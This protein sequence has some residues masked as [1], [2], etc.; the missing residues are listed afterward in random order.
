MRRPHIDL[1]RNQL[2]KQRLHSVHIPFGLFCS[3][4]MYSVVFFG[5]WAILLPFIDVWEKPSRHFAPANITEI[6]YSAM[7]DPVISDPDFPQNNIQI[8]LP[9]HDPALSISHQF[10][11]A[12]LFNPT[13][14][15]R[16]EGEGKRSGLAWFLNRMHYGGP[17]QQFGRIAYG[18]LAVAVLFL[19]VGGLIQVALLKYSQQDHTPLTLFSRW[20]RRIFV[21]VFPVFIVVTLSGAMF[22]IGFLSAGPMTQIVS[23]GR[24]SNLNAAIGPVLFPPPERVERSN[25]PAKMLPINQ[26]IRKAQDVDPDIQFQS[27]R[28]VHW[29]D[30]NARIELKGYNPY[31]PFLNGILNKPSVTLRGEDGSLVKHTGVMDRSWSVY[32]IEA[33]LFLHL[34]FGVDI[35]TRCFILVL[36]VGAILAIAC[37]VMLW[38]EKKA[39]PYYKG[40]VP[41]YHWMSKLSL[42][43]MIGVLPATALTFNLQWLIPIEWDD[44]MAYIKAGFFNLWLATLTWSFYR[45]RSHRAARELLVLGGILFLT[46]PL[47]H[48]WNS[49]FW[50]PD[51]M[52]SGMI[53]I[54]SVDVGLALLGAVLLFAAVKLPDSTEALRRL[55]RK[56]RKKEVF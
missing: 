55:L 45:I 2:F 42:A 49:G 20:H 14:R 6:D 39:K 8:R 11:E 21:W 38:L 36:M 43:V 54:L 19:I 26:L 29:K 4:M 5:I 18:L 33:T 53:T 9:G 30:S 24:D 52:R 10:T 16:I 13:T 17:L 47:I 32:V 31:R 12:I 7:I 48:F 35:F 28:L 1:Q 37:G 50:P 25:R 27:I 51:L 41:F 34:L 46:A 22:N 15:K 23:K 44:R 3:L 40:K 56:N